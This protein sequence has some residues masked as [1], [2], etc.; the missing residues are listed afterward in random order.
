MNTLKTE[1][2]DYS[3]TLAR[4]YQTTGVTVEDSSINCYRRAKLSNV[5]EGLRRNEKV[6]VFISSLLQVSKRPFRVKQPVDL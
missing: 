2:A 1:V 4:I 5:I 6:N 3:E